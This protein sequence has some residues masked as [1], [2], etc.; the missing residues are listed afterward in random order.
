MYLQ[1]AFTH[2]QEVKTIMRRLAEAVTYMHD[3]GKYLKQF[4]YLPGPL[5]ATVPTLT[6]N[7]PSINS[8]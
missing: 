3:K 7:K 4:C 1:F 8:T 2:I 6:I 5:Q